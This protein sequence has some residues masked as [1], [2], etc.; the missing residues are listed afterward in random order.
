M[1]RKTYATLRE[2]GG[3]LGGDRGR[4]GSEKE[5]D[6]LHLDEVMNAAMNE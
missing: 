6:Q 1:G 4:K 3:I 2:A 5:G